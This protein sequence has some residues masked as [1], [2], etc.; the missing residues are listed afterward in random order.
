[1]GDGEGYEW[2]T[3]RV[4]SGDSEDQTF[5]GGYPNPDLTYSK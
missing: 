2:V 4:M 5:T 1:M 3:V